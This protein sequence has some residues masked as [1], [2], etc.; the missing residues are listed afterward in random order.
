[1][2]GFL[3]EF[4]KNLSTLAKMNLDTKIISSSN[5]SPPLKKTSFYLRINKVKTVKKFQKF[6]KPRNSAKFFLMEIQTPT[7]SQVSQENEK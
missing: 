3:A 5:S 1:L 6:Q 4:E 7:P 2:K